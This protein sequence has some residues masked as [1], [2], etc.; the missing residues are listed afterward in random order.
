[1]KLNPQQAP[2]YGECLLTVQLCDEDRFCDDEDVEFYL[3]FAGSTQRHVTSTLRVSHV[4]LQAI[5]PAHNS[6]ESVRVTLCSARA[7]GSVDPVAEDHFQFVQDLALD[8]ANFLVKSARRDDWLDGAMLLDECKIP[9]KECE[10]LDK[11]LA[12]ALKHLAGPGGWSVLGADLARSVEPAPQ[13]TLLH[14]AARRGLRHVAVFLL[15]QPGGREALRLPNRQGVTPQGLAEK[16]GHRQLQH[17]FAREET[18]LGTRSQTSQRICLGDSVVWHHPRLNTYTLTVATPPGSQPD[19]QRDVDEL[20]HLIGCHRDRKLQTELLNSGLDHSDGTNKTKELHL[21]PLHQELFDKMEQTIILDAPEQHPKEISVEV[22]H[23]EKREREEDSSNSSEGSKHPLS[24]GGMEN[25]VSDQMEGEVEPHAE[26]LEISEEASEENEF[27]VQGEMSDFTPLSCGTQLGESDLAVSATDTCQGDSAETGEESQEEAVVSQMENMSEI[28]MDPAQSQEPLGVADGEREEHS[29]ETELCEVK[30]HEWSSDFLHGTKEEAGSDDATMLKDQDSVSL[31]EGAMETPADT[32]VLPLSSCL[33]L[34]TESQSLCELDAQSEI[35]VSEQSQETAELHCHNTRVCTDNQPQESDHQPSDCGESFSRLGVETDPD[36]LS[37]RSVESGFSASDQLPKAEPT[38]HPLGMMAE[39]GNRVFEVPDLIA[40]G[41]PDSLFLPELMECMLQDEP[42]MIHIQLQDSTPYA[43]PQLNKDVPTENNV[44][45]ISSLEGNGDNSSICM[46]DLAGDEVLQGVDMSSINEYPF[47]PVSSPVAEILYLHEVEITEPINQILA[48]HGVR[49]QGEDV[50]GKAVE[51]E[52]DPLLSS[53]DM[54]AECSR[55]LQVEQSLTL[56]RTELSSLSPSCED[57]V[58]TLCQSPSPDT[59]CIASS[60]NNQIQK[61]IKNSCGLPG[62]SKE[63]ELRQESREGQESTLR[64]KITGTQSP[65]N[66]HG[67]DVHVEGQTATAIDTEVLMKAGSEPNERGELV[68][69]EMNISHF[70]EMALMS[71][72]SAVPVSCQQ[73]EPEIQQTVS[74]ESKEETSAQEL[75]CVTE[76][77]SPQ[78][79]TENFVTEAIA[80]SVHNSDGIEGGLVV[81]VRTLETIGETVLQESSS[82]PGEYDSM[83]LSMGEDLLSLIEPSSDSALGPELSEVPKRVDEGSESAGHQTDRKDSDCAWYGDEGPQPVLE[84]DG[85]ELDSSAS[86]PPFSAPPALEPNTRGIEGIHTEKDLFY[87]F[88]ECSA[89]VPLGDGQNSAPPE[90]PASLTRPRAGSSASTAPR[91]SYSDAVFSPDACYDDVI[92]KVTGAVSGDSAV[93][94]SG[95]TG[96][97]GPTPEAEEEKD[98]LAEV[99]PRSAIVLRSSARS[100]SP[101]RR[102]SWDPSRNGRGEAEMSQRSSLRSLGERKH[103]FHKRSMSWCP[104]EA[105]LHPD[106]DD[107]NGR[108]YSLE[109]LTADRDVG[110]DF[111]RPGAMSQDPQRPSRMESEER[112]SLVSLTEE[113]QE[114]ELGDCSSLDSESGHLKLRSCSSVTLPLTKSI[115]MLTI[116]QKELDVVGRTRPK[117]RISFSFNISPILPKSKTFFS[118]GSSSSD[119]EEALSL[120]SFSSISGSLAYSISEEDP[121][122]LRGDG[123]GKA[124]TKVSRTFSYLRNKMYKKTKEKDKEK[125]TERERETKEKD[126]K[127]TSGHV[128]GVG[129]AFL[130]PCLQCNKAIS[131]KDGVYCPNCSAL[132]H[133]S[134]RETLPVCSKVRM[135]QPKSQFAVPEASVIP[136]VTL[137]NKGPGSVSR[138]RPWSVMMAP[139]DHGLPSM[140]RRH[141][142]IAAPSTSSLSKSVSISNIAGSAF[143]DVPLKGVKFLSYSTDSLNKTGKVNESTESLTDEGTEMMDSQLMGEFEVDAKELEADSWS[144]SVDKK[145]LK[146]LKKDV[147]KRQD[148]IYELIQTEM[149]HVRT[150]RI[151]WNV[152]SKGL[153]KEVQLEAQAVE[154]LFPMLDDLLD[155]HTHFF[156]SILDRKREAQ[157]KGKDGGFVIHKIGDVLFNQ[158]SGSNADRMKR[159]Y[160]KFCSRYNEAVNFYKELH[161]KDKRFQAFIKKKMS[162]S[163]VRRLGIRECILLVTQ[164]IT[165]YPVLLQ[166]I[167]QHTKE[168]E[169]DHKEV[170]EALQLVKEV[171]ATVDSKV[172]EHEKKQRLKEVHSRMDSKSIMRMKSGQMFAREDLLHGRKLLHDGPLQLKNSVG[173]L[174][175]VQALLLSDVVVFLQ[176]KDQKYV[177]ASLDQRSTVISLQKLIVREVANEEKGLFLITAGKK[178]EMLEVYASSKEERNTWMQLIQEAMNS[179]EKDEDEGIP[180]ETEEDKRILET[181]AKEM[182]ELL[183]S[184]DDQIVALLEEKVKLFGELCESPAPEGPG[185][186]LRMFRARPKEALRGEP[187]LKDALKIVETLQVIVSSSLG[188][189]VGHQVASSLGSSGGTGVVCLPRRAETFG[190][191]DSHQ[192]NTSKGGEKDEVEDSTDLRRTESDSVLKKGGNSNLLLLLKRN[193]EQVLQNVSHLHELLSTLQAVVTQ[194]DSL[195]EEQR[196]SLSERPPS[197]PSSRPPSLVEQEKQRSLE[198][199]RQ[200]AAELQRRQAA[201]AEERLR[202]SR[203]WEARERELAEREARVQAQEEEVRRRQHQLEEAERELRECKAEYQ[204]DLEGLR[205]AQRKLDRDRQQI[206]R[207]LEQTRPAHDVHRDR[208]LSST[209]DDSLRLQSSGSLDKDPS[210]SKLSSS[211]QDSKSRSGSKRKGKNFTLFASNPEKLAKPKEKK[212]K[213]KKKGKGQHSQPEESPRLPSS[214]P[215]ADGEIFFC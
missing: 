123:E 124:G 162:S 155:I 48:N 207:D 127:V 61:G 24:N 49:L 58:S 135:M 142:S 192:M 88:D 4:T 214:E 184:K 194:Q 25:G 15:Q 117:R 76:E 92:R 50:Q 95:P 119:E 6:C 64:S 188:G 89:A 159:V 7:G 140:P 136:V 94:D 34:L 107:I 68:I 170:A 150:L 93:L 5:C 191:F 96:S 111:A 90:S 169:E 72:P 213:K 69:I 100:L 80:C 164:R 74:E 102:H 36:E 141:T 173:R 9:L 52:E 101:V 40:S 3:L 14:F 167:L 133:R 147:I 146:Q 158:F 65:T 138:E 132:V 137:R 208:T 161:S 131:V 112:G 134:F 179:M 85:G 186:W 190:G 205:E 125:S 181:K 165:K 27:V 185:R 104:S 129:S 22:G 51:K 19:L 28:S 166:R 153:Q 57:T 12:L 53:S 33:D 18:A 178:P 66:T 171:V 145:F 148:V 81:P 187:V 152:Y 82:T 109:G 105:P 118:I 157:Q 87:T 202:Q 149:H 196:Q 78:M 70:S 180:S 156:S 183:R 189:S 108:S 103:M 31:V 115:S 209:S 182:R 97:T 144:F 212:D 110:R 201:H 71:H 32:S 8:M 63:S 46:G 154:R 54:P 75:C 210:E 1:M 60:I 13:E 55:D 200:E 175:D 73:L 121:G 122:P 163:I 215:S 176:E 206:H 139:E 106:P 29:H 23:F 174:K 16:R 43:K 86:L 198:R 116:S 83:Y 120:K 151:M 203:Q 39:L 67:T 195:V 20:R 77:S 114:Y 59:S 47:L 26:G 199:Q 62:D 168:T 84:K 143:D 2:L 113:E 21:V 130:A 56:E 41:A 211:P 11:N 44:V 17:L 79:S 91:D 38:Q 172:N 160:G 204:R 99:P 35:H 98:S 197:R 128:F 193:S 42:Q 177:F 45:C 30:E 37:S 10:R 126:K